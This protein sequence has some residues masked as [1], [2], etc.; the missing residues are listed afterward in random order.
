M[1]E[2][3]IKKQ[4]KELMKVNMPNG[5]TGDSNRMQVVSPIVLKDVPK[6]LEPS[7]YFT[8]SLQCKTSVWNQVPNNCPV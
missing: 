3:N 4:K 7:T 5:M 6:N 8:L 2:R 1:D